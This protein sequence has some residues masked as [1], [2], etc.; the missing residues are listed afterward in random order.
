[1]YLGR[2]S[3]ITNLYSV[4]LRVRLMDVINC[5]KFYRNRLR[6][7]DSVRG[8]QAKTGAQP[9]GYSSP[10][11]PTSN[12]PLYPLGSK[13]GESQTQDL[14][15]RVLHP[16]HRNIE[17]HE[18][19][20]WATAA[21]ASFAD[22][23]SKTSLSGTVS[24]LTRYACASRPASVCFWIASVITFTATHQHITYNSHLTTNIT[25]TAKK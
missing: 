15:S 20:W 13:M 14:W 11:S 18:V 4:A 5:A 2:R 25:V 22:I 9:W 24:P 16:S 21:E 8:P 10:S 23:M 6:G 17:L 1:M 19:P 12:F 7:L 3:H